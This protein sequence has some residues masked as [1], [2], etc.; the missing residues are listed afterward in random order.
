LW[1]YGGDVFGLSGNVII[2][3]K[4]AAKALKNYC[5][6]FQYA[7]PGSPEYWWHE[8]VHDFAEG[9]AAMMMMYS[10]YVS[11]ITD[12]D[13]SNVVGQVGFA[14]VPGLNPVLGGWSLSI[15]SSSRQITEALL[16]IKWA[17]GK[18]LSIPNTLLGNLSANKHVFTSNEI[19]MMYPWIRYSLEIFPTS[20][21]RTLPPN[22]LHA[23]IQHYEQIIAHAVHQSI[24][25]SE[26]PAAALQQAAKSLR[27]L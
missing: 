14:P 23:S 7:P 26:D 15:N 24:I 17:C 18:E 3:S 13:I 5:E 16:F 21:K 1:A 6:S 25:G 22:K 2:D 4:E 27:E 8:Q 12:S 11:S 9:K 19:F 10:S 20:K